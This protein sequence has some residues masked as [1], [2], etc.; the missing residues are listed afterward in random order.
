MIVATAN[1]MAVL[2]RQEK[3]QENRLVDGV[4]IYVPTGQG[5]TAFAAAGHVLHGL[6]FEIVPR[7]AMK[8][9]LTPF[10]F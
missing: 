7:R 3:G 1:A 10:M 2:L 6:N 4:A 8:G 9:S 5:T